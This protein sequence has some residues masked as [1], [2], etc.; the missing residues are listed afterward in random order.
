M[1]RV[2]LLASALLVVG[3]ELAS[4][5]PLADIRAGNQAFADGRFEQAVADFSRAIETGGLD[6]ESLALAYNNRGVA[7]GELGEF[8]RAIA[9]YRRALELKPGDP[10]SVR[11]L[12]IAHTRRGLA[13][14]RMGDIDRALADLA[15]AIELEP[16]HPMAYVRRAELRLERGEVEA[17]IEDLEAATRI[18]PDN[19]EARTQLDR[20]RAALAAR[21]KPSAVAEASPATSAPSPSTDPRAGTAPEREALPTMSVP[22]VPMTQSVAGSGPEIAPAPSPGGGGIGLRFRTTTDVFVRAEPQTA[23]PAIGSL[24]RGSEF[25]ARGE[26]KGWFKIDLADGRSGWLYRRFLEPVSPTGQ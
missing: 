4:A 3:S 24:R 10:K 1:L 15:K 7:L 23:S 21:S 18:A 19:R 17:A 6:S 14:A 2:I 9:D 16:S 25:T 13:A 12:R 22:R 26:N 20:A 8:D 5:D 11:N